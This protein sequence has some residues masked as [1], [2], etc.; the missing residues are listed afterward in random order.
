MARTV[1]NITVMTPGGERVRVAL[2]PGHTVHDVIGALV[3][4]GRVPGEDG[5]GNPI[6]YE[7]L[8]DST[9]TMLPADKPLLDLG[10]GEDAEFRLKPGARGAAGG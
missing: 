7:L 10:I 8:D 3:S 5:Q 4:K 1:V 6:R 2:E 9:M